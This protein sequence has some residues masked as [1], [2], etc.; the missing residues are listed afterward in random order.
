LPYF[1]EIYELFVFSERVRQAFNTAMEKS[2]LKME[3]LHYC[4]DIQGSEIIALSR[5][6]RDVYLFPLNKENISKLDFRVN[7][8]KER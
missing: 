2:M 7:E 5:I 1:T 6:S 3:R 4:N 8:D